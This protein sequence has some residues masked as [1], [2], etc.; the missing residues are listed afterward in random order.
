MDDK[1]NQKPLEIPENEP[2]RE[3]K[4][5]SS[6]EKEELSHKRKMKIAKTAYA[7]AMLIAIGGA[8][9]AK[10]ATEKTLENLEV[11]IESDY[12]TLPSVTQSIITE[13]DF[14]VRQNNTDVADTRKEPT[15]STAEKT[16]A[17]Q[18]LTSS[19]YAVPYK[20]YYT[21]P[22]GTEILKDY[23]PSTPSYNATMDDWR[24]HPAIDFK[25]EEGQQ[26]KAIAY[27]IVSKIY[28][29]A[30][31]GTVMEIDHGNGVVAR[32]C[33]LNKDTIDLST[34]SKVSGGSL[35]GYLGSVPYEKTEL[36]HL[37]LEI[38]YNNKYVDP[39]ELMGK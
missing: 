30:L 38:S 27:G 25:G 39:L 2:S 1:N 33:G 4:P 14:E 5:V 22:M 23:K 34:G 20:D 17:A 8:L 21:L 7:F 24:T 6:K 35:I 18:S 10:I 13:P 11:P 31:L 37:H 15:E 12:V 36:P 19:P 3:V 26:V 28:T 16:T 9:F 32:Y 29:D